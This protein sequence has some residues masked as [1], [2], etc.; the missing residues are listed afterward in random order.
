[1]K[2]F[3]IVVFICICKANALETA[4]RVYGQLDNMNTNNAGTS[5]TGLNN[6]SDV[7]V[8]ETGVYICDSMNRRVLFY[9]L[10]STNATRVYGQSDMNSNYSGC[11][12]TSLNAP[13]CV[14]ATKNGVFICDTFNSR[15]LF[16]PGISTTATVVYGQIDLNTCDSNT[17]VAGL[18]S[19][20]DVF[21]DDIGVYIS[22][23]DLNSVFLYFGENTT[24]RQ[25]YAWAP[26]DEDYDDDTC[27]AN[28]FSI[29]GF[30]R[31]SVGSY[32]SDIDNNRVLFFLGNSTNAT[33][34]YGQPDMTT[35]IENTSNTNLISPTGIYVDNGGVYV[36]DSANNR[37]LFFPGTS[38]I[39]M[40]V[41]GQVDMFGS[42]VGISSTTFN[43]PGDIFGDNTGL[44]VADFENNRV[45]F[46]PHSDETSTNAP[47]FTFWA[48]IGMGIGGAV[49][50]AGIITISILTSCC[51]HRPVC[52]RVD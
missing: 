11:S 14:F 30:F 4:T 23:F 48:L 28:S 13:G 44:Y 3:I 1:M 18:I 51:T 42:V 41:Y 36:S 20:I 9:P 49:V 26:K 33:R 21:V 12:S 5:S 45:L 47:L 22:D 46:F 29:S 52:C 15:V 43:T 7:F 40:R 31:D 34:V 27:L 24:A 32:I 6:P 37:V 16:F 25:L 10:L 2:F 39:A 35:C 38:T 8:D 19:P 17:T 50:I